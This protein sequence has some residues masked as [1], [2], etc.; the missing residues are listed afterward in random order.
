MASLNYFTDSLNRSACTAGSPIQS[1]HRSPS[2]E[3]SPVLK[4]F[5]NKPFQQ[6]IL[7]KETV[8][9]STF[10][11]LV[12]SN[13]FLISF[14]FLTTLLA[15][16]EE[17]EILEMRTWKMLKFLQCFIFRPRSLVKILFLEWQPCHSPVMVFCSSRVFNLGFSLC[18]TLR[19]VSFPIPHFKLF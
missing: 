6:V 16:R 5:L 19:Q 2:K 15:K 17:F 7:I 14:H 12:F 8:I 11:M 9:D 1:Y 10:N 3:S 18:S 4:L 13:R